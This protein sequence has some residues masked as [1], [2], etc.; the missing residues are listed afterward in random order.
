MRTPVNG[1]ELWVER[2]GRGPPCLLVHGGS[3][4]ADLWAEQSDALAS[5][6]TVIRYD[7]RG[8]NRSGRHEWPVAGAG[9]AVQHAAD[10]A[11]LL[12]RLA[13][14]PAVVCG[15][16]S[17]GVVALALACL[18]PERCL[19]VL[20]YEPALLTETPDA[21][22][23]GEAMRQAVA[24]ARAAN[25]D[26]W[27]G[28]YDTFLRS[29]GRVDGLAGLPEPRRSIEA[30]NAEAF[31]C[32]DLPSLT[33]WSPGT[34]ALAS[35]ADRLYVAIGS[36]GIPPLAGVARSLAARSS[37]SLTVVDGATHTPYAEDPD[38]LTSLIVPLRR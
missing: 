5:S 10:A 7:R 4:D 19:A 3:E 23:A 18:H 25:G 12:D 24:E 15:G 22:A 32:D 37:V 20:A 26:D 30:R 29:T 6:F 38:L 35:A 9:S 28:C 16:S 17:G 2:E 33:T 34:A 36:D 27:A 31:C 13:D 11:A 21:V 14:G 8:T 1:T